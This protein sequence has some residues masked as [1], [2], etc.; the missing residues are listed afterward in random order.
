VRAP[1]AT[2]PSSAETDDA[3]D[4]DELLA[5]VSLVQVARDISERQ[6]ERE[7][8]LNM[9]LTHARKGG[10]RGPRTKRSWA[11]LRAWADANDQGRL[12]ASIRPGLNEPKTPP[13]SPG[14]VV[15]D[16]REDPIHALA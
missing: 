4:Y 15:K 14:S 5:R 10:R 6:V 8:K 16:L 1:L 7:A 11:K 13:G 12:A 2:W 3:N 9:L